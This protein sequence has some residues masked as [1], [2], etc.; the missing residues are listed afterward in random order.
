MSEPSLSLEQRGFEYGV[1]HLMTTRPGSL[2]D[3]L[4]EC[5]TLPFED[6][7]YLLFLGA[8]YVQGQRVSQE[9]EVKLNTYIRVHTKPRRFPKNDG[10]W[11]ERILFENKNFVAVNKPPGLPCH[12]SVDNIRENLLCYLQEDLKTEFFLTHRLDV[13]TSGILV[14]AKSKEFQS[15]FNLLLKNR[16]LRKI[17]RAVCTGKAPQQGLHTHYMEPSPRAPK[18]V[19]AEFSEGQAICQ[20]EVLSATALTGQTYEV[21][22]NL[23]TGRTHQI[24]AQLSRLGSPIQG[25]TMYGAEKIY[26]D[27]R[28]DLMACELQFADPLTQ[29]AHH[30][31][32]H[33]E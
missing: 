28:I 5:L 1:K 3:V 27:E 26:A 20:L 15:A 31:K 7:S 25:D 13:P 8:I 6:L 19:S 21:N 9:F 17:Y 16:G 32:I 2:L 33:A 18:K 30:I 24:R 14:V 11:R 29:Q 23:M 10:L 4:A 12:P 22:I